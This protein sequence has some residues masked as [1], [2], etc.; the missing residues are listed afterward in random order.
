[1]HGGHL[2]KIFIF[3]TS[4]ESTTIWPITQNARNLS[5]IMPSRKQRKAIVQIKTLN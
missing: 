1:M 3:S 5:M 4:A 2:I